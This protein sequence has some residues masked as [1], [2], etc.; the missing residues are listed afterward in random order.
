LAEAVG[1]AGV[2]AAVAQADVAMTTGKAAAKARNF[3]KD[4]QGKGADMSA[5]AAIRFLLPIRTDL[6]PPR[7][8]DI[9]Y[10]P[11]LAT[12]GQ[13]FWRG[14]A[15]CRTATPIPKK[16]PRQPWQYNAGRPGVD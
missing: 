10:Y 3:M 7:S 4:S 6:S 5:N 1:A 16:P 12:N 9:A 11:H 15:H 14:P 2:S 8:T 13:Q